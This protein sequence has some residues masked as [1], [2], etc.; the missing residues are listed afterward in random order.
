MLQAILITMTQQPS[1]QQTSD[2]HGF[3]L[4][5]KAQCQTSKQQKKK[6]TFP[7]NSK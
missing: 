7:L 6:I 1:P 4:H 3:V 2:L 5:S